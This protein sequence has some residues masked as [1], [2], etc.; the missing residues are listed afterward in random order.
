MSEYEFVNIR[1]GTKLDENKITKD[2]AILKVRPELFIEWDFEKNEELGLIVYEVTKWSNKSA[3]WCCKVYPTEHQWVVAI[4]HRAGNNSDCPYCSGRYA[5]KRKN[6]LIEFPT[7]SEE[8]DYEK[9]EKTPDMYTPKSNES[10]WWRCKKGHSYPQT[11]KHRANGGECIYCTNRAI[12]VGFNDMATTN[13]QLANLL[14]NK[15]DGQKYMQFSKHKVDW[16]CSNCDEHI[17][18]KKIADVNI[19]GLS[20][21]MCS[22]GIKYPERVMREVLKQ[23]NVQ[24]EHGKPFDWS[25]N[26]RFDFYIPSLNM[27]IET[28]GGQHFN[29]GFRTQGGRNLEEEI[30]NDAEKQ[31]LALKNNIQHY[32]VID[33]RESDLDCIKM[34]IVNSPLTTFFDLSTVDWMEV[35]NVAQTSLSHQCL[36][37]WND[38]IKD[39]ELIAVELKIHREMVRRYLKKWSEINKCDFNTSPKHKRKIIQLSLKMKFIK[40]WDSISSATTYYDV[41]NKKH[42][43]NKCLLGFNEEA[44]GFKWLY[45]S[46][47]EEYLL[48]GELP[49]TLPN[50]SSSRKSVVKLNDSLELLDE[51]NSI[52]EAG[53]KNNIKSYGHISSCCKGKRNVAGGFKWMYRADYDKMVFGD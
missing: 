40:E 32:I 1:N 45:K 36:L 46:D 9:N 37:L 33:S 22:G 52:T 18:N 4:G 47:Y 12:L 43:I 27:I 6:F 50:K 23:L 30:N 15:N 16:R 44:Y 34:N 11:I 7:I 8:W 10:V 25:E 20:C 17:K 14:F 39:I 26:K 48:S 13:P 35:E 19:Y 38:G 51:Y 29:G 3:Y 31:I 24:F 53:L 49:K 21:S 28:H 2:N 5:S 42:K 41:T